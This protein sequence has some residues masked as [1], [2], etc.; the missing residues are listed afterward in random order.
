M[1]FSISGGVR[2][3]RFDDLDPNVVASQIGS[4]P[5]KAKS[6][7]A[8]LRRLHA[9]AAWID[10]TIRELSVPSLA[11]LATLVNAGGYEADYQVL[12]DAARTYDISASS[13]SM[14]VAPLLHKL[15]VVT[16]TTG[17]ERQFSLVEPSAALVA[18][19]L[20]DV[21]IAPLPANTPFVAAESLDDGRALLAVC[22]ALGHVELKL[23]QAGLPHRT[24]IKRI[25][26]SIGVD[27][28]LLER[29]V[30]LGLDLDVLATVDDGVIR[31][32][33]RRLRELARGSSSGRPRPLGMFI[34]RLRTSPVPMSLALVERWIAAAWRSGVGTPPCARD[35]GSVPGLRRGK[36]GEIHALAPETL[37]GAPAA[38]ITPSFEVF[39]PPESRAEH[40][41]EII[42]CAE[43]VRLD[44]VVVARITKA[45]IHRAVAAGMSAASM[46]ACLSETSRTPLPQNVAAAITDWA[47]SEVA[48][49]AVGRVVV[50][51]ITHEARVVKQLE[52]YGA[53]VIA[54]GV[55]LV[56]ASTSPRALADEL[57]RLG[58]PIRRFEATASDDEHDDEHDDEP[59][60]KT[61]RDARAAWSDRLPLPGSGATEIQRRFAAY[62]AGDT[63]E[64]A[65]VPARGHASHPALMRSDLANAE[66]DDYDDYDD[67]G[68]F[69]STRAIE[70]IESWEVAHRCK[71][72]DQLATTAGALL[73]VIS[74]V[75]QRFLL[76][77]K[78]PSDLFDRLR[79]VGLYRGGFEALVANHPDVFASV[80]GSELFAPGG[81]VQSPTR[82][83]TGHAGAGQA[84]LLQAR[85][86]QAAGASSISDVDREWH[87]QDLHA[88][89]VA[90][91]RTHSTY[92]LGLQGGR[93]TT[94]RIRKVIERGT[95]TMV[96]GEDIEDESAVAVPLHT[97]ARI[98][99]PVRDPSPPKEA[100]GIPSTS[101]MWRPL[102]GQSPPAG[103]VPCPCGSGS[104]Y[105]SCCRAQ[106]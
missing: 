31:P 68:W 41:V 70:R 65:K 37:D 60:S 3:W 88:R 4:K 85:P 9:D 32:D 56:R 36:I 82:P 45:S 30:V 69:I 26:K 15:L 86:G 13:L 49:T 47:S 83:A 92:T 39:V 105:R 54:P 79:K 57:G 8:V 106:N 74:T 55:I 87:T 12:Q 94:V 2:A 20:R 43:L 16:T 40:L 73:D 89:L 64:L 78:N 90:A 61:G 81:D 50:V 10:Q 95:V 102:E 11:I 28:E 25:A 66:N 33:V 80:L 38:S 23:T 22:G 21:D 48:V 97:I 35:L 62:R 19:R 27:E 5:S 93:S 100:G 44:R 77:A 29:L 84:G 34:E 17:R 72:D 91:S 98:A 75:D 52:S 63:E 1:G 101:G 58:V 46:L 7:L 24:G 42:A 96:L 53:R 99:E 6:E 67:D 18:A 103:H 59:T 14:A 76:G 104:R 71:L 51:P